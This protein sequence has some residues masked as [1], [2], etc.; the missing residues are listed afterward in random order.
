[1]SLHNRTVRLSI[2][3][4][5]V[6]AML[7]PGASLAQAKAPAKGPDGTAFYSPSAKLL[8]GTPGSVIWSRQIK[9]TADGRVALPSASKTMLVLYRSR[10]TKGKA[11]A[12]S[13]TVDLP[14]GKAPK[15]GWKMVSFAH[16]TTGA[17]DVCAPSRTAAGG[18]ADGYIAYASAS[19][20]SWLKAGYAVLRTDYEGLGTP[21]RHPYLIGA[22]EGRGVVDIALAARNLFGSRLLSKAWAIGGHSQGGHAALFA[23][24]LAPKL[25]PGLSLKGVFA[26]APASHIYE[27]RQ[28]I[29]ILGDSF[30]AL[31][32][33][34]ALILYSAAQEAGVD[35]ATLV[36]PNIAAL[37]GQ[38]EKVCMTQLG[39]KAIFGDIAPN[40]ILKPG[41]KT[42]SVDKV[43]MAMNPDVKI[44]VPVLILQGNS[45]TTVFANF[46]DALAS[47]L[48]KRGNKVTYTKF[49]RLNHATVVTD[50]A[51]QAA[52]LVFL[53]A[54][55]GS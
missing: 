49:D 7:L 30:K 21:G 15:R 45:D 1:M 27:Q 17:A 9:Y 51:P 35:P 34:A 2:L 14:K 8:K 16:G 32:G 33:L 28:A 47:E 11:I 12:V 29:A 37:L 5:A 44:S 22:S 31:T 36:Q 10:S 19:Y 18:P 43:L 53:R 4:V 25:A 39:S 54:R 48:V 13:G 26:Y 24:S 3:V 40:A 50:A 55:L 52:V 42:D 20:D 38:I 23:A 46:T 6:A 41:I